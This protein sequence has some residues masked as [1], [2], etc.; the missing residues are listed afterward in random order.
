MKNLKNY[1]FWACFVLFF[2]INISVASESKLLPR[3]HKKPKPMRGIKSLKKT[4]SKTPGYLIVT[5][6]DLTHQMKSLQKFIAHKTLHRKFNVF[7]ATENDFVNRRDPEYQKWVKNGDFHGSI[8]ARLLVRFLKS[9]YQKLNLKYVLFIG[10]AHPEYGDLPMIKMGAS[11]PKD[12]N[13][14]S[15][16]VPSACRPSPATDKVPDG[17]PTDYPYV[18]LN[19]DYDYDKDGVFTTHKLRDHEPNKDATREPEVYFGRIPYYGEESPY[20]K[21]ADM[22]VILERFIRYDREKDIRWRYNNLMLEANPYNAGLKQY[23]EDN[24]FN[25]EIVTRHKF[26]PIGMRG[27]VK[28]DGSKYSNWQQVQLFPVT[29]KNT[30]SHGGPRGMEGLH[31][32][33]ISNGQASDKYP[34]IFTLGACSIGQIEES[35]NLIYTLLRFQSVAAS[36]GTRSVTGYGGDESYVQK[37]RLGKRTQLLDGKS[38][39]E[40]HW[41]WYG[42]LFRNSTP[43]GTAMLI[44]L[45]GDPSAVPFRDGPLPK[46]PFF[47]D[48]QAGF[49]KTFSSEKELGGVKETLTITNKYKPQTKI[50]VKSEQPWLKASKKFITIG[51]GGRTKVYLT[52]DPSKLEYDD[53]FEFNEAYVNFMSSDGFKVRRRLIVKKIKAELKA[54]LKFEK[55]DYHNVKNEF[56]EES[57]TY[58]H[59]KSLRKQIDRSNEL[60]GKGESEESIRSKFP[61]IPLVDGREGKAWNLKDHYF[62]MKFPVVEGE[63]FSLG[64]WC[65]YTG[66]Q[67]KARLVDR[68]KD[69][70]FHIVNNK[71]EGCISN[72]TFNGEGIETFN[73]DAP[74]GSVDLKKWNHFTFTLDQKRGKIELYCNAQK[75]SENLVKKD[76]YYNLQEIQFPNG[77]HMIDDVF[78]YTKALDSK[79][80]KTVMNSHYIRPQYP[81]HKQTM[82][83]NKLLKFQLYRGANVKKPVVKIAPLKGKKYKSFPETED[84]LI[85]RDLRPNTWYKWYIQHSGGVKSDTYYFKTAQTVFF[86]DFE[87]EDT[88]FK[89]RDIRFETKKPIEGKKS[90]YMH[91]GDVPYSYEIKGI[92]KANQG[93]T[94]SL[95]VQSQFESGLKAAAY[96]KK[97]GKKKYLGTQTQWRMKKENL[98]L[99]F[100]TD[101]SIADNKS[102]FIELTNKSVH[103]PSNRKY[104]A[105]HNII[106][107]ISLVECKTSEINLPPVVSPKIKSLRPVFKKGAVGT[108]VILSKYAKDPE[109]KSISFEKVSGPEWAYV[110]GN[111][112]FSNFG[113]GDDLGSK[114]FVIIAKDNKGNGAEFTLKVN[115]VR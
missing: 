13:S 115:A 49:F 37:N 32:S 44:N 19:T 38:V 17:S 76:L 73:F 102:I 26:R 47:V 27:I 89:H 1:S 72:Y 56:H 5:T 60:K 97:S 77:T 8:R 80:V 112:L 29:F 50:L 106:D 99:Q 22:D 93:Y 11:Y 46:S 70:R 7:L 42:G 23:Y 6:N 74:L 3:I 108:S 58:T 36:G 4:Y 79:G 113:P 71:I 57:H 88:F 15:G 90:L 111:T 63:S 39:G 28:A 30:H 33:T 12:E 9:K 114:E 54:I 104:G 25:Y 101:N 67:T 59:S 14:S 107:F 41:G 43:S 86:A 10:Y 83:S 94:L 110:Q 24:G 100:K 34:T 51:K 21:A 78:F 45:Y 81:L 84:G 91:R 109:G 35:Q 20:G 18:D 55:I 65:K 95:N 98:V 53:D 48:N 16:S 64:F 96:I 62:Y 31:S 69:F 75:L 87:G 52:I 105:T 103:L 40:A 66:D 68:G 92:Y 61:P 2:L 82:V 85:A